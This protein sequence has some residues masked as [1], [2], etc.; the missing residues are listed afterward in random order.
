MKKFERREFIKAAALA[1]IALS[2]M[3]MAACSVDPKKK[4]LSL[5]EKLMLKGFDN[6]Q[7]EYP[8]LVTHGSG[9]MWMHALRRF[10]FPAND[11]TISA[12]QLLFLF[13]AISTGLIDFPFTTGNV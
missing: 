5:N 6:E 12:I 9:K 11:E 10:E 4:A 2:T 3:P 13:G 8:S 1:S 7:E